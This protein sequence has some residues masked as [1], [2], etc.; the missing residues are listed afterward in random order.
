MGRIVPEHPTDTGRG[1]DKQAFGIM[2]FGE[3]GQEPY[4]GERTQ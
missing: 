2:V 1:G 4:H 3:F